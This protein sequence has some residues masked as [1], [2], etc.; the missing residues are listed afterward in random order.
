M[1]EFCR[2]FGGPLRKYFIEE[3]TKLSQTGTVL[4][5]LEQFEHL[6]SLMDVN[7][8]SLSERFFI[9]IFINGLRS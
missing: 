6:R 4:D 7:N 5:Y 1:E 2:R 8:P 9:S 3:F